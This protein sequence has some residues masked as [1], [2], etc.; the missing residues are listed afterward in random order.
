MYL[1]TRT[2]KPNTFKVVVDISTINTLLSRIRIGA[3][4]QFR[5]PHKTVIIKIARI[6][7]TVPIEIALE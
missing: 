7:Q 3:L 6:Q 1:T 4:L 5:V 2:K